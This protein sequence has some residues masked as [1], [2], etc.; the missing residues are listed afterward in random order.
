MLRCPVVLRL[1]ISHLKNGPTP[2]L[3]KR[4]TSSKYCTDHSQRHIVAHIRAHLAVVTNEFWYGDGPPTLG[5]SFTA[6][7]TAERHRAVV[8][9]L[10]AAGKRAA[11]A[12]DKRLADAYFDVGDKLYGCRPRARCG[13]LACP[14]CAR[15]FQK[16][17]TAAQEALIAELA[18]TR[19]T[20]KLVMAKVI[21]LHLTFT[22]SQLASRRSQA[23]PVAQRC[24]D[25]GRA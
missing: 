15:A 5:P 23:E 19:T 24:S 10:L 9:I 22:A 7:K 4:P 18:K 11:A 20:R 12:G 13:S 16:A 6:I 3:Q 8:Q 2:P 25:Q 21:P 17:K 14:K 1:L